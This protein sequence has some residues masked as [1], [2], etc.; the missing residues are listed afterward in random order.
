MAAPDAARPVDADEA[1]R[2]FQPLTGYR[3]IAL[4]V[5]GGSDSL[6]LLV[7]VARWRAALADGPDIHV[8]TVDHRL[9][10]EARNE[11]AH[12]VAVAA[13]FGLPAR[14]LSW[15]GAKPSANRQAAARAARRDLLCA[16]LRDI[17]GDALVLA[18]HLNDQ[19][20]TF[21]LRLARGSGVYGLSAMRPSSSWQGVTVL[22]PLLEIGKAR[23]T[24]SLRQAGIAW[25]EDP[26]NASN[27][28]A[29][30]RMRALMPQLAGEGL[31]PRRLAATAGRLS[32]AA[33]ALDHWVAMV[34]ATAGTVHPAGVVC[35]DLAPL[36]ELPQEVLLRLVATVLLQVTG[37]AYPPRLERLARLVETLGGAEQVQAT[38][39]GAVLRRQ[40]GRL[41]IWREHGR[42]GVAERVEARPCSFIWDGRFAVTGTGAGVLRV[43]A[44]AEVPEVRAQMTW[45]EGWPRAAFDTAPVVDFCAERV[46]KDDVEGATDAPYCPGLSAHLPPQGLDL[47]PLVRF[48]RPDRP[49]NSLNSLHSPRI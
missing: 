2:L 13:R 11:T 40:E 23:L 26:S 48:A 38:L 1:G 20:E 47:R 39:A 17:D 27:A 12:V 36:A 5:S 28:Y 29:R 42:D 22:R 8:F 44:L 31:S 3:R 24:A 49:K 45:P 14:V 43:R 19:A 41:F 37:A 18:H 30:V 46:G 25:H 16:G 35:L 9:R 4:A 6:A 33:E 10:P 7:L 32:G 21:L 34:L 15:T